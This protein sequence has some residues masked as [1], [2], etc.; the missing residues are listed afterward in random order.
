MCTFIIM[1]IHD[2]CCNQFLQVQ[3][4]YYQYTVD[5]LKPVLSALKSSDV[6]ACLSSYVEHLDAL[7]V[8]YS[9]TASRLSTYHSTH[10]PAFKASSLQVTDELR[11]CPTNCHLHKMTVLANMEHSEPGSPTS[12]DADSG[13]GNPKP[14]PLL[15]RDVEA[16]YPFVTMA[17]PSKEEAHLNLSLRKMEEI[18]S[19]RRAE[20]M[21]RLRYHQLCGEKNIIGQFTHRSIYIESDG[22]DQVRT[23]PLCLDTPTD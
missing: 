8:E 22:D 5:L 23:H 6:K 16:S 9:K 11:A 4:S 19:L 14:H 3:S 1:M 13:S 10:W 20:A 18:Q 7:R 15:F 21:I 17:I 2:F 12:V